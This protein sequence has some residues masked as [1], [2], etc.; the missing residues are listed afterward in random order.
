MAGD[1]LRMDICAIFELCASHQHLWFKSATT[2]SRKPLAA[3]KLTI[4]GY[5]A[6]TDKSQKLC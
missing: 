3:T 1:V 4:L 5:M 2:P 6:A